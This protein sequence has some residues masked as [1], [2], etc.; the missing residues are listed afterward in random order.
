MYLILYSRLTDLVQ[1]FP[2]PLLAGAETELVSVP[3]PFILK[4]PKNPRA[5]DVSSPESMSTHYSKFVFR[6]VH[7]TPARVTKMRYN[8]NMTL[9]KLFWADLS[10]AVHETLFQGP[11]NHRERDE[12]DVPLE[13][14]SILQAKKYSTHKKERKVIDEEIND[15][16]FVVDDWDESTVSRLTLRQAAPKVSV[17]KPSHDRN[18]DLQWTIDWTSVYARAVANLTALTKPRDPEGNQLTL[19]HVVET[20]EKDPGGASDDL[21]ASQTM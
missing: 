10:L 4:V 5:E 3:D 11:D 19:N 20:L 16:E 7:H 18:Q 21:Y 2:C 9:I 6:Q 1:G 12:E 8:P 14:G 15:E 17:I 13:G